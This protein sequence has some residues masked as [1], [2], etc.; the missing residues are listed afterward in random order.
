MSDPR[1]PA[2]PSMIL[3]RPLG[4]YLYEPAPGLWVVTAYYNPLGYRTRRVNYDVFASLLRRSG[5]PVL[6]VECAFGDE[7]FD[8]PERSDVVKVRSRSLLWQKERLL[9]LAISWLP[10]SCTHV[11]WL[12]CDLVF[13]N[14]SWA[15]GTLAALRESAVVQ[16]F[17]TCDRL[18]PDYAV[19]NATSQICASFTQVVTRD[20]SMLRTGRFEDHGHTGYGWAASRELLDRHGLYEHA[21]AGS[22]DHYMAHAAVGD[23]AS[24]CCERMMYKRPR[25]IEHFRRWAAGFHASVQGRI[26]TVPGE[27]LHLWHGELAN[28]RYSLRHLEFSK[29]AF[30]PHTDL[31]ALPGRPFEL[32]PGDGKDALEAWFRSFFEQR[33]EDGVG[34]PRRASGSTQET[35]QC[36][37]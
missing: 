23:V 32:R 24:A 4:D 5:I 29:F 12:D 14:P 6:T 36:P 34:V 27:V 17:E 1:E 11:A 18:P 25:L 35:R 26:G 16:V 37:Q 21:I 20:P 10:P 2:S 15:R 7:G 9:N 31:V 19:A 3:G 8:L 22:A 30:D 28:R 13:R 33:H